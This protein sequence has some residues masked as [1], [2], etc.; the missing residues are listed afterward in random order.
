MPIYSI[1]RP[2]GN[3]GINK[4]G[5]GRYMGQG[6]A[7]GSRACFSRAARYMARYGSRYYTGRRRGLEGRPVRSL[8]HGPVL[9]RELA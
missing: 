2:R 7:E 9:Y 6:P 3:L 4:R 1:V 8:V 5:L